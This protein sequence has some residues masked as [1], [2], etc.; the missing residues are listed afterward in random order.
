M[1]QIVIYPGRFQPMLS[2]HAEVYD[3]L[4]A[5]F[6]NAQVF[7]GTSDKVDG[8]KSPFNFKEKQMIAQGHGID[9]NN[10]KFARSPYV[11]TFYD[12]IEDQDNVSVIFAVGEKDRERFTFDNIDEKTGL[13]MK[14]NGEP[15]YYQ[16][17]NTYNADNPVPMTK[18]GY[19]YNVPNIE[20]DDEEIASASA[21]RNA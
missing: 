9:A 10:V 2:H 6:P 5:K 18:R 8:D 20:S 11:H 3:R 19:I 7:I 21:F 17:I 4:Q 15:Y 13:N 1:K 12:S 14:Q 16:M